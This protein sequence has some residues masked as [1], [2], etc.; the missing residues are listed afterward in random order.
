MQQPHSLVTWS[1]PPR[2]SRQKIGTKDQIIEIIVMSI[3]WVE[4]T[5]ANTPLPIGQERFLPVSR[6]GQLTRATLKIS[7]PVAS[8][9]D[10]QQRATLDMTA[11]GIAFLSD[12]R[13]RASLSCL[14]TSINHVFHRLFF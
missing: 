1:I 10:S 9:E 8:L 11:S 5:Q 4:L 12:V 13:V 7:R 2:H 14:F 6:A 3:N